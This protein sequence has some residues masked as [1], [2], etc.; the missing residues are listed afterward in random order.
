M[1][2]HKN[3]SG[4]NLHES[5]VTILTDSPVTLALA[6]SAAGIIVCDNL[7]QMW[8]ANSATAGD[9]SL[10]K[11]ATNIDL[12]NYADQAAAMA[13]GLVNGDLYH[14]DGTVM[15]VYEI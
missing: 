13:D 11:S 12:T 5:K 7:N 14:T 4:A 10:I 2:L 9:W 8:K 6:A 15:I 1:A 3:L